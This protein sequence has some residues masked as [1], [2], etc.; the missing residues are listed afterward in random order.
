MGDQR[1]ITSDGITR[2][3][4]LQ[5]AAIGTLAVG[6]TG[7]GLAGCAPAQQSAST[8]ETSTSTASTLTSLNP[9]DYTYMTNSLTVLPERVSRTVP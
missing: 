1:S 2:R 5:N 9:Q 3:R 8:D 6:V 4:F 7:S